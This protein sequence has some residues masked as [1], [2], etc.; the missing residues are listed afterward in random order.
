MLS[1]VISGR[2]SG[3]D[4]TDIA[5]VL[6]RWGL[7]AR[8]A[9]ARMYRAPTPRERERWHALW[10]LA[11]GRSAN[12]VADLPERDA[13]TSGGWLAAFERDG[14]AALAFAQTGGPPALDPAAQAGLQIAVQAAPAE[15]GIAMANWNGKMVCQFIEARCGIRLCRRACTRYLH[16]LGFAYKRPQKRLR[17]ADAA[18]RAAFVEEYAVLRVEARILGAKSSSWTRRIS[19]PMRT[20]RENGCS[21]VARR[22]S[23]RPASAGASRPATTR[24]SVWGQARPSI[25]N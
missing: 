8:L 23:T 17:K 4:M 9:R 15:V 24:R 21:R 16:R 25:G 12:T 5:G 20:C 7:D 11:H 2:V 10:L 18:K 14:P 19:A 1:Q 13:Y 3:A 22:W 6:A